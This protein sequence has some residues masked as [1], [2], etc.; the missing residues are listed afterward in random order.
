MANASKNTSNHTSSDSD[1]INVAV[2]V[3]CHGEQYL[4]GFRNGSQHQGNRYEFVGGKIEAQENAIEGL[5]REVGEETGI[6]IK[7]S[8]VVKLGRLH[9][10]YGDKQVHLQVYRVGLTD[11]Q[12]QQHQYQSEGLEGQALTWVDKAA[13][14]RGDYPLPAANQTILSWLQLPAQIVITHPISQFAQESDPITTWLN[15]HNKAIKKDAWVY[16]RIKAA[17]QNNTSHIH[18]GLIKA[19]IESRPDIQVILPHNDSL[20]IGKSATNDQIIV[21]HINHAEL[22]QWAKRPT[23]DL[24]SITDASAHDQ[25]DNTTATSLPLADTTLPL[26]ISCHDI[27]SITVANRLAKMRLLNKQPPV[28]AIFL[29]PVLPTQSHPNAPALGW[30]AWSDL[31]TLADTPVIALGGLSPDMSEAAMHYGALSVA[32]IRRFMTC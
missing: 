6:D 13:L 7:E 23:E 26:I 5:I 16:L 32:G 19:L 15:Y 4:L 1:S 2:A 8:I 11:E 14:L 27:D 18:T 31:A 30:K 9:H 17:E 21:H 12:Y 22:M 28:I 25:I 24:S 3:I 10:D 20:S 29:S